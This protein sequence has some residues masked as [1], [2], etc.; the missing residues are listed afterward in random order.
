MQQ[1][2]TWTKKQRNNKINKQKYIQT[3]LVAAIVPLGRHTAPGWYV[4]LLHRSPGS[5]QCAGMPSVHPTGHPTCH[6]LPHLCVLLASSMV[7]IYI[8]I[9]ILQ[10][11]KTIHTDW[12]CTEL[13]SPLSPLHRVASAPRPATRLH[14]S[15][16]TAPRDHQHPRVNTELPP[17]KRRARLKRL[18]ATAHWLYG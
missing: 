3:H 18:C 15:K 5:S 8:Y 13:T 11:T 4:S 14:Q 7:K 1:S 10:K 9:Y 6:A 16:C 17:T 12:S 2:I